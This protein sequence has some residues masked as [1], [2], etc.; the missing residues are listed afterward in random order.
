MRLR[1]QFLTENGETFHIGGMAGVYIGKIARF[2]GITENEGRMLYKRLYDN[3]LYVEVDE[4]TTMNELLSK[5]EREIGVDS[6]GLPARPRPYDLL[7]GVDDRLYRYADS[8]LTIGAFLR[9]CPEESVHS[10]YLTVKNVAGEVIR[11]QKGFRFRI[12]PEKGV[13]HNS[14][15]VHVVTS[16]RAYETSISIPDGE[17]LAHNSGFPPHLLRRAQTIVREK[18]DELMS[19][20]LKSVEGIIRVNTPDDEPA[21][22][23]DMG[24][25]WLP[26]GI[27]PAVTRDMRL[28]VFSRT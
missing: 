23:I 12:N 11:G 18:S 13:R 5:S 17:E 22:V 19:E 20:W 28:Y 7:L 3:P 21:V 26:P 4:R 25:C 9:F 27:S 6:Q 24:P 8:A 14:A 1:V 16:D 10:A 15:H 2:W